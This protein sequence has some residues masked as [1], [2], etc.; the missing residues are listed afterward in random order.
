MPAPRFVNE[1]QEHALWL[2][3]SSLWA[4]GGTVAWLFS[5][6]GSTGWNGSG[7]EL[8][9]LAIFAAA[10]TLALRLPILTSPPS[11]SLRNDHIVWLL[12][13]FAAINWLGFFVLQTHS[14]SDAIPVVLLFGL[15]ETWF[16]T[17]VGRCAALPWLRESCEIL[18]RSLGALGREP[19]V[20]RR[21][22]MADTDPHGSVERTTV[23]GLDEQGRRYLSGTIRA[24]LAAEQSTRTLS[25]AFSP[26]FAGEPDVDFEFEGPEC[27]ESGDDV[28]VYLIHTTPA[29]MRLGLR[30]TL[31]TEAVDFPLQW[32]AVEVELGEVPS[33]FAAGALP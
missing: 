11:T 25:I 14:W 19:T 16:H 28:S 6:G 10:T 7:S 22:E 21:F 17:Q 30:R 20:E 4:I 23:Q 8:T 32:Y 27:E 12:T 9:M 18:F 1:L 29:G 5:L 31:S 15:A 13:S 33:P 3:L 26:P 24:S 2:S